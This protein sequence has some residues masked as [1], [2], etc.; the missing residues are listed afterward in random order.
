ME[1]GAEAVRERA[2]PFAAGDEV[3]VKLVEPH[4]Y[5]VDDAVAKI[6]GYI[7]SVAG[8]GAHMGEERMVKIEEA[9]RNSASATLLD[10]ENGEDALDSTPRGSEADAAESGSA[11][12]PEV[13]TAAEESN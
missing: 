4:M 6:D 8:G 12:T 3:L 2:V 13:A 11:A 9:G 1:G 5:N 7:V 10:A